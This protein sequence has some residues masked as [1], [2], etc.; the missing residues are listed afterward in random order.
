MMLG[1]YGL[2][3]KLLLNMHPTV[4]PMEITPMDSGG[5]IFVL[6]EFIKQMNS[7]YEF[8]HVNSSLNEF[9]WNPYRFPIS[10]LGLPDF[11]SEKSLEGALAKYTADDRTSTRQNRNH[12]FNTSF[13]RDIP[14]HCILL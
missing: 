5:N 7:L 1:C 4:M 14:N 13:H 3:H 12:N 11:P 2:G 8:V 6:N 10:S 9:I